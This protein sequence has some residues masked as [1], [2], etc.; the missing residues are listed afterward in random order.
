M[1]STLPAIEYGKLHYRALERDKIMALRFHNGHFDRPI[2]ISD[3]GRS[4]IAWWKIIS[5]IAQRI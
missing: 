2:T 3:A 5:T 4:D 1:I